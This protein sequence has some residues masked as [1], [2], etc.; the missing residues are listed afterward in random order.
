MQ[1]KSFRVRKFRN[2]VDSGQVKASEPVTCLVGKNE[3]GKSG[4]L[5]ALYLLNPAYK[6]K[7][8]LEKQY[9]RWLLAKDRRSGDL[10]EVEFISAEFALDSDEI[11][12]LEETLGSKLF[13]YDSFKVT[14]AYSGK[15][16]W[17]VGPDEAA[18]AAHLRG[19][20]SKDVQKIVGKVSTLK[21]LAETINGIDTAAHED[22][23]G[24]EIKAAKGL[25]T[26]HNLL[27]AT[28]FDLVHEI[29]GDKLPTF[30][31]FT[32]YNTL[33]GRIDLREVTAADEEPGNSAMQTA[34]AL[35]ALAGTTAKQLSADD[36]EQRRGEMEAVSIDLTNQV[37]DYW[38]QNPDLEVIIDVDKE[39]YRSTT[40]RAW[41]RDS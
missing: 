28:A 16:L 37:F 31:R 4:A 36:Y 35:I 13:N 1:L 33:P 26:E 30:F 8:D 34:R 27:K 9:P 15:N 14:R 22:V 19:K 18:I 21:A 32:G 11:A 39:K 24:G 25:V 3:A 20:L 5:E 10:S 40:E 41:R 38:K 17:H 23:D 7:P 12:E 29:I 6:L 2:I